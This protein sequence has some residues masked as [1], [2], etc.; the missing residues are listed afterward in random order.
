MK[1]RFFVCLSIKLFLKLKVT[2]LAGKRED[3]IEL[4]KDY[5]QR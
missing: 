2:V 4:G 1:R 3:S 5:R